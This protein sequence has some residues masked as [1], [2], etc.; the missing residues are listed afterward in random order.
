MVNV[1]GHS[2]NTEKRMSMNKYYAYQIH[3]RLNYYNLLP[4][5]R[6]IVSAVRSSRLLCCDRDGNDLGTRIVLTASFTG[7]PSPASKVLEDIDVDQYIFAELPNPIEVADG[8]RVISKL[9]MHGHCG[10]A[11]K[12]APCIKDGNKCNRN[13]PKPYSNNTYIDKDGFVHYQRRETRIDTE[14]QNVRLDN[15]YV[16]PYNRTLCLRYYP[17]INVEYYGWTMLIKYLFKYISKGTD[18]V[19]ANITTPIGE[20]T[21]TSNVQ[22]IQIDEIQNF[23]EARYVSPHEAC[24]RILEFP[25]HYRDLAVLTLAKFWKHMSEDI[26]RRLSSLLQILEIAENETEMKEGVLFK[27]EAILNSNSKPLKDFGLPMPPRR[28]LDILQNRLLM[29]ERNYKREL[30]LIE[31]YALLPKLNEDQKLILDEVV[32]VVNKNEQKLI[33]VYGYGGT[34]KTFLWNSIACVIRLEER[35][36]LAVASS[37]ITSL[38]FSSGRTAHS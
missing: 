25:I 17:H 20:T 19:V 32:N 35:I 24:W 2:A 12:N 29:E 15:S 9:I 13:F 1:P 6:G 3:D 34:G 21:S 11:N 22:N 31:K 30:L 18:R 10:V 33:F 37:S 27:I 28:L 26:P 4:G 36:V 8:Y 14:R 23:V 5:G 7:G 16:V 38:L